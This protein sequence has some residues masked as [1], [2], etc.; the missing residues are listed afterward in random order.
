VDEHYIEKNF[1]EGVPYAINTELLDDILSMEEE[2]FRE[3]LGNYLYFLII[4]VP[5]LYA[6]P[7]F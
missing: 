6:D 7:I 3:L 5:H 4:T 2:Y 1:L